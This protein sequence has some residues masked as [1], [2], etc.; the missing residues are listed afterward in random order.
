M[1]TLKP[2]GGG[3]YLMKRVSVMAV[4]AIF[5]M[6]PMLMAGNTVRLGEA[7]WNDDV[8]TVPLMVSN[9]QDIMAMDIPLEY[10]D[11]VTLTDV[12]F[13]NRVSYFDAK[14]ANI[15]EANNR[16]TIGLI[17]MVYE[18]KPALSKAAVG[19]DAVVANLVFRVDDLSLA[20]FEVTPYTSEAPSHELSLVYNEY[21]DNVPVV[22]TINPTFENGTVAFGGGAVIPEQFNLAQNA[23]NPFN[24]TTDIS[25]ALPEAGMVNVE[26]Y[27]IL[28]QQ[29]KTLVN[30]YQDAG[31]YTVTWNGDDEFGSTVASGVYFYRLTSGQYK[32][33]KKMVMMK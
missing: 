3:G 4:L 6:V 14:L 32:E 5:L 12:E 13:T 22:K 23:P 24:P 21:E 29:V 16:V 30:E 1:E 2:L 17:S 11:G 10:S 18:Q 31:N 28:G 15:D 20:E 7:T 19:N 8:V 33:I 9:D 25:Y 26:V 27:N